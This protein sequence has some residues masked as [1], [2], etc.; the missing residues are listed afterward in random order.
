MSGSFNQIPVLGSCG[1]EEEQSASAQSIAG[2]I[3]A[4]PIHVSSV[5]GEG[6]EPLVR[7]GGYELV[8]VFS[9]EAAISV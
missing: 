2:S 1:S 5:L 3:L 4:L 6:I 7:P 9:S 8:K